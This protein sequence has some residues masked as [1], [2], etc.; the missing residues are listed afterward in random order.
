M[1][2]FSLPPG[3][4]GGLPDIGRMERCVLPTPRPLPAVCPELSVHRGVPG[5]FRTETVS[6]SQL[7]PEKVSMRGCSGRAP[8][9][10]VG[11]GEG[12]TAGAKRS[13]RGRS[14]DKTLGTGHSDAG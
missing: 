8:G 2:S 12:T 3:G 4:P 1:S 9:D 13:G 5:S 10:G 7:E 6:T 11:T 14:R